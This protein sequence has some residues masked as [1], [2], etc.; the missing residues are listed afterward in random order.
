MPNKTNKQIVGHLF[1]IIVLKV[2]LSVFSP[3]LV[4]WILHH[5][6]VNYFQICKP[7][8]TGGDSVHVINNY[9]Q[10]IICMMIMMMITNLWT[11]LYDFNF[12]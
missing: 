9:F 10:Q 8:S 6:S 1:F 4:S 3:I 5:V 7:L 11:I 12:F 2:S